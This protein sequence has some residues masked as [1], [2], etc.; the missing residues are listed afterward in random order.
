MIPELKDESVLSRL[1]NRL[2]LRS[3]EARFRDAFALL[4]ERQLLRRRERL[5]SLAKTMKLEAERMAPRNVVNPF[6]WRYKVYERFNEAMAQTFLQDF[7]AIIPP[8]C[9]DIS[10]QNGK[11]VIAFAQELLNREMADA[12]HAFITI[13]N[14]IG[15]PTIGQ[16]H[17]LKIE[18]VFGEAQ[19]KL[20]DQINAAILASN[21]QR[22]DVK[23]DDR[24]KRLLD[25]LWR[26]V[27]L[28]IS[29]FLGYLVRGF[30]T[31]R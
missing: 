26:A 15:E 14:A 10:S 25:I 17:A 16:G 20:R 4:K 12:K 6:V 7:Q 29:F 31:V 3:S 5:Q 8:R 28:A 24:R 23:F 2:G 9:D 1:R 11:S 19:D 22:K 27:W 21:L 30:L 18:K 13:G